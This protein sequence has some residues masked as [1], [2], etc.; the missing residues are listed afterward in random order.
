MIRRAFSLS[1]ILIL[2]ACAAPF[3]T[4][5]PQP[6]GEFVLP[7]YASNTPTSTAT[8]T[9]TP[10]T[11][12]TL[13]PTSAPTETLAPPTETPTFAP[14][15]IESAPTVLSSRPNYIF[16]VTLDFK[17]K[18]LVADETIRY[19]NN[20]GTTLSD[21]V[22]SVQPNRYPNGF[23]L[24]AFAQ[25]GTELDSY[26]LDGQ[27]LEANLNQ[28]LA[29][30]EATTLTLNFTL[31]L[32]RKAAGKVFG[33]DFNQ[34]NLTDWYPFVVPYADGWIL[35][36]PMPWGEHLVY[37]SSDIEL[38]IKS[39][40]NVVFAVGASPE[41]NGEWTRYRLYGARTLALSASDSF[42]VG[43]TQSGNI[44]VRSYY[45]DGFAKGGEAM[46]TYASQALQTYSTEF[47]PYPHQTLAVV[48]A[49]LDDGMEYG[50][51]VFLATDF[52]KQYDGTP[53]GNL[54]AIG[55]HEIAHQ[56]WY[57]LVGNDQAL[58][59]WLDEALATY[60]ERIF[61]ENNY[62][63]NISWWWQFRV[64]FFKPLG[65]ADGSVYD[66]N[67]FRAYTNAVYFR[68]ALFLDALREYM[69]FGNYAKLIKAYAER[70]AYQRATT[71]DFFALAREIVNLNYDPLIAQYFSGTY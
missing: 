1:L 59:P 9:F 6:F 60:S 24:N 46:L 40:A 15:E 52:Y 20:S 39:D 12:P 38:D 64:N 23:A 71:E 63:A 56:W 3:A 25:D 31:N 36:D 21:L 14:T 48:Q 2:V 17:N 69:G 43:E 57:E 5:A 45:F 47:A 30:N 29:P 66:Y 42:L 49:D 19:Y 51:L 58:E 32:P 70:Y 28:P 34:I 26:A 55:V 61:Y 4:P 18:T 7:T 67:S 62:P 8:E 54:T 37:D 11:T 35:H 22:L 50:G 65:F 44:V 33:Y 41:A 68:G 10:T 53:R 16:Y 13:T 27:R